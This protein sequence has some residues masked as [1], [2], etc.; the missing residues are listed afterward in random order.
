MNNI[1]DTSEDEFDA[2][3]DIFEGVDWSELIPDL[4]PSHSGEQSSTISQMSATTPNL[5]HMTE[6]A[7]SYV[8]SVSETAVQQPPRPNS[9]Q[10][11]SQYSFDDLDDTALAQLD[12]L[13][14]IYTQ[15]SL[16]EGVH[17]SNGQL[18]LL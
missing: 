15:Q 1:Q 11:S 8:E 12:A 5:G 4:A 14:S 10:S 18:V 13:E 7:H 2:L 6:G 17:E 3:P 9:A 16:R